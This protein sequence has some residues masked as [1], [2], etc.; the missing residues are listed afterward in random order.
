MFL[1]KWAV[2][3]KVN[4]FPKLGPTYASLK[5]NMGLAVGG[6]SG[7]CWWLLAFCLLK[8]K[9]CPCT[10][11]GCVAENLL[12]VIKK[13]KALKRRKGR[14]LFPTVIS[15]AL[16]LGPSKQI[17]AGCLNCIADSDIFLG[18][19]SGLSG[20]NDV[21]GSDGYLWDKILQFLAPKQIL[22]L[23]IFWLEK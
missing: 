14:C 3:S 4:V 16:G 21:F 20:V 2:A 15:G 19:C 18:C 8:I 5:R 13:A 11:M 10:G 23:T 7:D 22:T 17:R 6:W 1:T 9:R 12:S